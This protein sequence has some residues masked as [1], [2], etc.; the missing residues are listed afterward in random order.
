MFQHFTF[1]IASI[2]KN[3]SKHFF[4]AD[5]KFYIHTRVCTSFPVIAAVCIR[6]EHWNKIVSSIRYI[7]TKYQRFIYTFVCIIVWLNIHN[8]RFTK[9]CNTFY[10]FVFCIAKLPAKSNILLCVIVSQH[11][12]SKFIYNEVCCFICALILIL[13]IFYILH[14]YCIRSFCLLSCFVRL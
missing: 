14:K 13:Y 5:I 2:G 11:F 8:I 9:N 12:Q 3:C 6:S 7:L 1:Y 10:R 4:V